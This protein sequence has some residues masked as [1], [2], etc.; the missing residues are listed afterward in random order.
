MCLSECTLEMLELNSQT[1]F[2]VSGNKR[3]GTLFLWLCLLAVPMED[4]SGIQNE[5]QLKTWAEVS[6]F[7]S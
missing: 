1:L 2:E 4:G 6:L 7:A 3:E 5:E